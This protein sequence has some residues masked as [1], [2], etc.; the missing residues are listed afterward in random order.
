MEHQKHQ[1][2]DSEKQEVSSANVDDRGTSHVSP[3]GST[4]SNDGFLHGRQLVAVH[5]GLLTAVFLVA[6][7]QSIVST[8]LPRIV[9]EFNELEQI[10]WVVS[11]YF[12][13]SPLLTKNRV[14]PIDL[15]F[16]Q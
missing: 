2:N 14:F 13:T 16:F 3:T 4:H 5:A 6:L 8:A 15:E 12:R 9:S 7:D 10:T 1:E 11:A